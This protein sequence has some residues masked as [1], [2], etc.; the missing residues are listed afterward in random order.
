MRGLAIT[1]Y[2]LKQFKQNICIQKLK[3][4]LYMSILVTYLNFM[5]RVLQA[6]DQKLAMATLSFF[7][8]KL[9]LI[10]KKEHILQFSKS[11]TLGILNTEC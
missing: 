4:K 1:E 5:S 2:S 10:L 8:D 11:G 3:N 7:F 6:D 9:K